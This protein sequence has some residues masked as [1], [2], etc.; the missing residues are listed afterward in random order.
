ML[1]GASLRYEAWMALFAV[2]KSPAD[3]Y[4]DMFHRIEDACNKIV[5]VTPS[6]LIVKQQFDEI[7]LFTAL[8]A[9]P[10]D[11]LLTWNGEA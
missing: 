10:P 11:D 5:R 2:R 6:D 4:C 8:H 9:L 1:Q 3:S 7:S